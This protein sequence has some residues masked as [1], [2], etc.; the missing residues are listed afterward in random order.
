MTK[1]LDGE[2]SNLVHIKDFLGVSAVDLEESV[3]PRSKVDT[4]PWGNR[5]LDILTIANALG[6]E[7]ALFDRPS[8]IRFLLT[9]APYLLPGRDSWSPSLT[10][11]PQGSDEQFKDYP[12]I[13]YVNGFRNYTRV[14]LQDAENISV[15]SGIIEF[16]SQR[17]FLCQAGFAP[18]GSVAVFVR[19]PLQAISINERRLKEVENSIGDAPDEEYWDLDAMRRAL[20]AEPQSTGSLTKFALSSQINASP[21]FELSVKGFSQSSQLAPS[22][23]YNSGEK[24]GVSIQI[25]DASRIYYQRDRIII[26]GE[27][28]LIETYF[29]LWKDG[30]AVLR[31]LPT[32]S[33][34]TMRER[35]ISQQSRLRKPPEPGDRLT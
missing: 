4:L 7:V 9:Y 24:G 13:L 18:N 32:R 6:A 3:Q 17:S 21:T 20:H 26:H 33:A 22:A 8:Y 16:V 19:S 30:Q 12:G 23:R 5:E 15:R 14:V 29:V 34:V 11:Y 2:Y 35:R 27:D 28:E 10:F 25:G 1:R 31:L